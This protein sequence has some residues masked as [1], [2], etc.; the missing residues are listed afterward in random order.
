MNGHEPA[1]VE[2]G[3]WPPTHFF[4]TNHCVIAYRGPAETQHCLLLN[5]V[6][7]SLLLWRR[8]SGLPRIS[9]KPITVWV[10]TED[11]LV[12]SQ[13]TARGSSGYKGLEVREYEHGMLHYHA[14]AFY[15]SWGGC[16]SSR[17]VLVERKS[18]QIGT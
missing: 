7:T 8:V 16:T 1:V 17:Q 11:R 6:D 3:E 14:M 12:V 2:E 4:G 5:W 10:S 15:M 18:E 9:L 13:K